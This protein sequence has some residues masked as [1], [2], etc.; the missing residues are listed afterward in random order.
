MFQL[1][2]D[3]SWDLGHIHYNLSDILFEGGSGLDVVNVYLNQYIDVN[4]L[5]S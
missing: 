5:G 4:V 2:R 3:N 1:K